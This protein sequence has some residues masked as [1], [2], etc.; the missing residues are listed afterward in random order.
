MVSTEIIT[1]ELVVWTILLRQP[2]YQNPPTALR[3]DIDGIGF[4]AEKDG[5][6]GEAATHYHRY[7]S[8]PEHWDDPPNRLLPIK[9]HTTFPLA[10]CNRLQQNLLVS[11]TSHVVYIM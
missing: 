4:H 2:P 6:G 11:V 9:A 8:P 3:D 1:R 7:L 10:Y 5:D